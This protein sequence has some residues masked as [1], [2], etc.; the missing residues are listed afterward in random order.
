MTYLLH[1]GTTG[2][3][4]GERESPINAI[5]KIY[6]EILQDLPGDFGWILRDSI[7][8]GELI[9][10]RSDRSLASRQSI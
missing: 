3:E 6:Y 2:G 7:I 9:I 1:D 10:P 5:G 4:N 8:S